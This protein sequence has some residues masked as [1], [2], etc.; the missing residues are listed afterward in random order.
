[1]CK[2]SFVFQVRLMAALSA[3]CLMASFA[4]SYAQNPPAK[5]SASTGPAPGT[6]SNDELLARAAKLY[7]ST[8]R[9]G[10]N[11]FVCEVHP[12]WHTIFVSTSKD[13]TIANDD[14]RIALLKTV[15]IILHGRLKGG[16]TVDWTPTAKPGPPIDADSARMLDSMHGGTNQT[17]QG[18]MQFWTPFVDG[19]TIPDSAQGLEIGNTETGHTIHADLSG[20]S[21]TESLD[22]SLILRQFDVVAGGMT[23]HFAPSFKPTDKGL[24]VN[25]FHAQIQRPGVQPAQAQV[26][27]VEIEYQTVSGFPIPARISMEVVNLG[28]FNFLLD[29]CSVNR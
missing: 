16:S 6:I 26:M 5:S 21:L 20:T 23:V 22:E 24:L 10:L 28:D 27:N 19:S 11:S 9:A 18:F 25:A 14:P 7:Y 17:L 12:D 3:F 1:M 15:K 2:T 4:A 13:S 29:G 8:T